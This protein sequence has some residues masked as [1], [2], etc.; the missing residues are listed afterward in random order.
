MLASF[1]ANDGTAVLDH[2][3]LQMR[4]SRIKTV[5]ATIGLAMALLVGSSSAFGEAGLY[6]AAETSDARPSY[7]V[8]G[9]GGFDWHGC[10]GGYLASPYVVDADVVINMT[11]CQEGRV[12]V[13]MSYKT[14]SGRGV[15]ARSA[16]SVHATLTAPSGATVLDQDYQ[17]RDDN[18]VES[19]WHDVG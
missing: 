14:S 18:G 13:E 10:T 9:S 19:V 3:E 6:R 2:G 17:I 11:D 4:N 5:G 16:W 15:T 1:H 12:R 7:E 8:Q